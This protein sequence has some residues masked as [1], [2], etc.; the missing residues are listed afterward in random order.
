MAQLAV[1]IDGGY[2]A[3]VAERHLR[4]WMDFEKLSEEIRNIIAGRGEEPIDLLRT[5]FYDCLPYQSNP[6]TADETEK[7]GKKRRFFATLQRLPKYKVREG[8]LMYRGT[9]VQ[10]KPIFQQKRV[11]LMIGLDIAG[12]AA[13]KRITHVAVFS[14]DSDLLPAVEEAQ[15]EG[16]TVWLVHGPA[17]TYA[18]E[19]WDMAD[20]RFSVDDADFMR[21]IQRVRRV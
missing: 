18:P 3:K 8:R 15:R 13:K 11:D 19:L 4:I 1:F 7:F 21:K 14:G 2:A 17:G 5:Y 9:D 12:L 6:P 10:G 16:V 20:E